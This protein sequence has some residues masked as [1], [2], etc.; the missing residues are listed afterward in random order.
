M[1]CGGGAKSQD[2]IIGTSLKNN[3]FSC[4]WLKLKKDKSQKRIFVFHLP[5]TVGKMNHRTFLMQ[6]VLSKKNFSRSIDAST[7]WDSS[8]F[9]ESFE[10]DIS[11]FSTDNFAKKHRL[12]D[13]VGSA[14]LK[15]F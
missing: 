10:N 8:Y 2:I 6:A 12:R 15:W 7:M 13:H 9:T 1:C 5:E 14:S 3:S 4:V 11:S